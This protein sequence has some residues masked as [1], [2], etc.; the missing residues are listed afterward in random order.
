MITDAVNYAV[1]KG[2]IVV[3][4]SGNSFSEAVHFP[5][6]MTNTLAVGASNW[7]DQRSALF[8]LCTGWR[9]PG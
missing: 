8:Q 5:A 4:S 1:S 3:A 9:D 2:V 6:A 7:L